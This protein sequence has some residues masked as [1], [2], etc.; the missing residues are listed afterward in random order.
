MSI[1]KY[2][3]PPIDAIIQA[4]GFEICICKPVTFII[5]LMH[6]IIQNLEV[7]IYIV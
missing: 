3:G 6:S 4:G 5:W 1:I 7:K 2:E